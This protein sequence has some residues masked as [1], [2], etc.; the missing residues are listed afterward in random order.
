MS[1]YVKTNS[2]KVYR[3]EDVKVVTYVK[4]EII[5]TYMANGELETS[6]YS[7][8]SLKDGMITFM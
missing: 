6:R 7:E 4:G 3:L 8:S 5:I 1:A 2:G